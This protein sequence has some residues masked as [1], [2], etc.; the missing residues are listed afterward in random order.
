MV[1]QLFMS[2]EAYEEDLALKKGLIETLGWIQVT[3][4]RIDHERKIWGRWNCW[5]VKCLP[6]ESV[7]WQQ[8]HAITWRSSGRSALAMHFNTLRVLGRKQRSERK[9]VVNPTG[10]FLELTF[11]KL[12]ENYVTPIKFLLGPARGIPPAL[13]ISIPV[14]QTTCSW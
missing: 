8:K 4:T 13:L 9:A 7:R 12:K 1:D 2:L 14:S 6:T 11:I 10:C 3:L 5:M